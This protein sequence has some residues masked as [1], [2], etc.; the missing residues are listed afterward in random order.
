MNHRTSL[1]LLAVCVAAVPQA[2][3]SAQI[4][5]TPDVVYGHKFGLA[6]TCDVFTP[7]ADANGAGVL[8]M[9]SGGMV[10]WFEKHLAADAAKPI[11]K[12]Q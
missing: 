2:V 3:A 10:G 7:T 6:M 5:I 1:W 11:Q 4:S 9:V 12:D 8:F